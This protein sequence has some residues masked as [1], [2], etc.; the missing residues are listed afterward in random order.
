MKRDLFNFR[1]FLRRAAEFLDSDKA[2]KSFA[3]PEEIPERR[4]EAKRVFKITQRGKKMVV[5]REGGAAWE[6]PVGH[7]RTL[8]RIGKAPK[9]GDLV[10]LRLNLNGQIAGFRVVPG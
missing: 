8:Q 2:P 6:C 3:I 10:E 5:L 1:S 9:I 7:F 4:S